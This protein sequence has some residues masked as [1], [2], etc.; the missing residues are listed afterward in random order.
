M[1]DRLRNPTFETLPKDLAVFPLPGA[2]LL[3]GGHMPLNV[4]EPRYLN[5]IEDAL[6]GSRLIGMIQPIAERDETSFTRRHPA[7]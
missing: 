3:P 1:I 6:K 5:M 4:F 2:M 7:L